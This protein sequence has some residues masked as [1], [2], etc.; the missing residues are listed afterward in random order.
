M[1]KLAA[2]SSSRAQASRALGDVADG[3]VDLD[4]GGEQLGERQRI[5]RL[6]D[7]AADRALRGLPLSAGEAQERQPRLR[8]LP[9]DAR[10]LEAALGLL[11]RAAQAVDLPFLI[12]RIGERAAIVAGERGC[13]A[14]RASS[15]AS[16]QAP[17]ICRSSAR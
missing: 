8:L 6:G 2:I 3:Q 12:A 16:G 14:L 17:P 11:D 7:D 15:I 10:L 4:G 13:A 5:L 1:A 9:V